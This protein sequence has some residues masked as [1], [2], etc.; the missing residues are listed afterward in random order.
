MA[1][2]G[3][4][5]FLADWPTHLHLYGRKPKVDSPVQ[6]WQIQ[7]EITPSHDHFTGDERI[8]NINE[9]SCSCPD[10]SHRRR[11]REWRSY[12]HSIFTVRP[13]VKVLEENFP[14]LRP[15]LLFLIKNTQPHPPRS[16]GDIPCAEEMRPVASLSRSDPRVG[17]FTH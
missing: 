14:I 12:L 15:N 11:G 3:S 6:L 8:M 5:S 10:N 13:M 1:S 9:P 17:R 2:D 4:C 16:C 7:C